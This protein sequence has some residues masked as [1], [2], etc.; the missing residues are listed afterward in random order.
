MYLYCLVKP[1]GSLIID[2]SDKE[3]KFSCNFGT[4]LTVGDI[5]KDKKN[6]IFHYIKRE[7]V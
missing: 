3:K 1:Y 4:R 6:K 5:K 7:N 2:M